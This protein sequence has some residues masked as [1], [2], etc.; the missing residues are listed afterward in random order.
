MRED[1]LYFES[2]LTVLNVETRSNNSRG[3]GMPL[4]CSGELTS[5]PSSS[6]DVCTL[7]RFGA[8]GLASLLEV[9]D[10]AESHGSFRAIFC[11]HGR[12]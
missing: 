1:D 12:C 7:L 4:S 8:A 9:L 10:G 5:S 3:R 2:Q 11:V 6:A